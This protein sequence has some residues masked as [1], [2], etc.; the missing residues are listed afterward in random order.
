M[1]Q[2]WFVCTA[3]LKLSLVDGSLQAFLRCRSKLQWFPLYISSLGLP[4]WFV[5][6][7][8][9]D[10]D[11]GLMPFGKTIV[12]SQQANRAGLNICEINVCIYAS[13]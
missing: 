2:F 10:L 7:C 5:L 11:H 6:I 13:Q 1:S 9:L 12:T 4:G 8:L 3:P